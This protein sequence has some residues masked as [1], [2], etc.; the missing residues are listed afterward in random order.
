MAM[1]TNDIETLGVP[2]DLGFALVMPNY[3]VVQ[4][5]D[6]LTAQ[7]NWMYV[8]MPIQDQINQGLAYDPQQTFWNECKTTFPDAQREMAKS[9]DIEHDEVLINGRE[10]LYPNVPEE[11]R[12]FIHGNPHEIDPETKMFGNGC[13]F[14]AS[15]TTANHLVRYDDGHLWHYAAPQ[16]LRTLRLMLSENE[17]NNMKRD[18]QPWLD[19]F[20]SNVNGMGVMEKLELHNPLFDAAKEALFACWCFNLLKNS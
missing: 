6:R 8:R 18:V 12:K 15:I 17:E 7:L 4:I 16:N 9:Y 1:F 13:N 5:P 20:C 14:D 11:L 2:E 3:A 19:T 10:V